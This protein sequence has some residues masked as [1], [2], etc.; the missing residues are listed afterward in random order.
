MIVSKSHNKY[1]H[2]NKYCHV[3]NF[4]FEWLPYCIMPTFRFPCNRNQHHTS[5]NEPASNPNQNRTKIKEPSKINHFTAIKNRYANN[6]TTVENNGSDDLYDTSKHCRR[7]NR[8]RE[9][10]RL[11]QKRDIESSRLRS[12]VIVILKIK[13]NTDTLNM[14]RRKNPIKILRYT[15][16]S[17]RDIKED[18]QVIVKETLIQLEYG[19]RGQDKELT[20]KLEKYRKI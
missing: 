11:K 19:I 5:S 3:D 20:L 2:K 17:Y 12:K 1:P 6:S 14:K 16:R 15:K 4:L 18:H 7:W 13:E 9:F 8:V 10:H